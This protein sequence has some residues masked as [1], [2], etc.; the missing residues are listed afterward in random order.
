MSDDFAE[1]L[2]EEFAAETEE[3][4]ESIEPGLVAIEKDGPTTETISRLFRAFHSIKGLTRAMDLAAMADCAHHA[5]NLLGLVRDGKTTIDREVTDLLLESV[6]A[7]RS[8]RE[9]GIQTRKNGER[10]SGLIERLDEAYKKRTGSPGKAPGRA[11]A[12]LLPKAPVIVE[13]SGPAS[14]RTAPRIALPPATPRP[15]T[16]QSPAGG[17]ASSAEQSFMEAFAELVVEEFPVVAVA[18]AQDAPERAIRTIE[19]LANA[20]QVMSF[21]GLEEELAALARLLREESP[22]RRGQA[23][24]ALASMRKRFALIDELYGTRL[25]ALTSSDA[26]AMVVHA[27]IRRV[28][29]DFERIG[30]SASA[31]GNP[32]ERA[33]LGERARF[34]AALYELVDRPLLAQECLRLDD[35]AQRSSEPLNDAVR[36]CV[37]RLH[38]DLDEHGPASLRRTGAGAGAGVPRRQ[39]LPPEVLALALDGSLVEVLDVPGVRTLRSAVADEAKAIYEIGFESERSPAITRAVLDWLGTHA[40][41][42][43]NRATFESGIPF[44]RIVAVSE[45]PLVQLRAEIARLAGNPDFAHVRACR[46]VAERPAPASVKAPIAEAK[47]DPGGEA[48]DAAKEAAQAKAAATMLRVRGEV[49]DALMAQVGELLTLSNVLDQ[50]V[51]GGA[52]EALTRRVEAVAERI[53]PDA[54]GIGTSLDALLGRIRQV[55]Q[56]LHGAILRLRDQ[57]LELRVVPIDTVFSRFPRVVR[58]LAQKLGKDVT[59]ETTGGETRLDKAMSEALVDPL[60]HMVRNAVDH[61]VETPA[62]RTARGKNAQ[63]NVMLSAGSRNN[64]IV[65]EL[66]DD[67]RGM[68]PGK[69]KKRAIE[70]GILTE[71]SA[72][73]MSNEEAFKLIFAPGFSTAEQVTDTSGRGVGM[74]VVLTNVTKLGGTIAI[75]STIDKGTTFTLLLPLSAA[76][77]PV[78]L[79]EAG[80]RVLAIPERFLAETLELDPSERQLVE[81]H[82]ALVLRDVVLPLHELDALLEARPERAVVGRCPVVVVQSGSHRMGLLVERLVGRRELYVKEVHPAI[83]S[84]PGLSGAAVLGDGRAALI[85][86][87]D[88]LLRL[89]ADTRRTPARS[90]AFVEA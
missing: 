61:G 36:E 22:G 40:V 80:G 69:L 64:R 66:S 34:L 5:E 68:D 48:R 67:G 50:A 90:E 55:D 21:E 9:L 45:L 19:T 54:R 33:L 52:T 82:G 17:P 44:L 60:M 1:A 43:V 79:V 18:V 30:T 15:G 41:P 59:F 84:I 39:P 87:G 23:L 83:V 8:L 53:G 32:A 57:T 31:Q 85:V 26:V 89:A 72:A 62:D 7:L 3:H 35:V 65:I 56:Q 2:W 51:A 38:H 70:R 47:K 63:A 16:A 25:A 58:T 86:D 88:E 42:V 20:C 27:E 11:V 24:E 4:L 78:L 6:D 14:E 81:G 28:T 49:V 46:A 29:P 77:Q 76:I 12:T 13:E 74:D 10:P 75:T 73:A 37:E 71:S